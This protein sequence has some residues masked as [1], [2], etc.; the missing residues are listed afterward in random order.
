M[1]FTK[2]L[3]RVYRVSGSLLCVAIMTVK[4]A[5]MSL[6]SR[7]IYSSQGSQTMHIISGGGKCSGETKTVI[8]SDRMGWQRRPLW[9]CHI[10]AKI[11]WQER[12]ANC[13]NC[14]VRMSLAFSENRMKTHVAGAE[15]ASVWVTR[16]QVKGPVEATCCTT[17]VVTIGVWM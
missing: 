12:T 7:S 8:L 17:L 14:K 13:K 3:L 9:P 10:W 6:R 16:N 2:H 4:M 1:L 11:E 15:W 5:D